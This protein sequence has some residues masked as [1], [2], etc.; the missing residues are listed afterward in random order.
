MYE[1]PGRSE[2]SRTRPW[3]DR[4]VDHLRQR[5]PCQKWHYLQTTGY[6]AAP[7]HATQGTGF[8]YNSFHIDRQLFGWL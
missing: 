4:H 7:L 3:G 6:Y 5:A 2:R 1:I 8:F